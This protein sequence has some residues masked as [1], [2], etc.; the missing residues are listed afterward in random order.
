MVRGPELEPFRLGLRALSWFAQ[1]GWSSQAW[2]QAYEAVVVAFKSAEVERMV[3]GAKSLFNLQRWLPLAQARMAELKSEG[4]ILGGIQRITEL[5]TDMPEADLPAAALIALAFQG[6]M[7]PE[8]PPGQEWQ[9]VVDRHPGLAAHL[10]LALRDL[11]GNDSMAALLD[12]FSN[13]PRQAALLRGAGS[14]RLP[15]MNIEET[16]ANAM[17]NLPGYLELLLDADDFWRT[18]AGRDGFWN[19]VRGLDLQISTPLY[20]RLIKVM[21]NRSPLGR[22]LQSLLNSV[23]GGQWSDALEAGGGPMPLIEALEALPQSKIEVGS[24]LSSILEGAAPSI[25]ANADGGRRARWFKL[26]RWTTPSAR[27]ALLNT[28]GISLMAETASDPVQ[29]L[30]AG[31]ALLAGPEGLGTIQFSGGLLV[32]QLLARDDGIDWLL[33]HGRLVGALV[34]SAAAKDQ[35]RIRA[36]LDALAHRRPTDAEALRNSWFPTPK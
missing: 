32:P 29:L 18:L 16:A 30:A 22:H 3:A 31:G 9:D 12:L 35:Q 23:E 25:V 15:R 34:R 1:S 33:A 27:A 36:E 2:A 8:P 10:D 11:M 4:A 19:A 24:A 20:L 6:G 28:I 26:T 14:A 17:G 13:H 7:N 5:P 21:E